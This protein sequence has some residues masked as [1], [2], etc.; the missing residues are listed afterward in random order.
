MN[1]VDGVKGEIARIFSLRPAALQLCSVKRGCVV[2]HFSIPAAVAD[3]I[4]P[5]SYFK[6]VA[7]NMIG[8]RVLSCERADQTSKEETK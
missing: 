6:H 3:H 8:V 4:F 7:L 2:L 1:G 5:V